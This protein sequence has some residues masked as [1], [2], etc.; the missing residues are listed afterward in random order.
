[1]WHT[2]FH[3]HAKLNMIV[4]YKHTIIMFWH[5]LLQK[6]IS[7]RNSACTYE[8]QQTNE[9]TWIV[10]VAGNGGEGGGELICRVRIFYCTRHMQP[11]GVMSDCYRL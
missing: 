6:R 8:R 4:H 11:A 7:V 2:K 5:Q 1:M 10:P 3:T 9:N